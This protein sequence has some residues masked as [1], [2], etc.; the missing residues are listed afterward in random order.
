MIIGDELLALR[1]L[2][3]RPAPVVAGETI[4]LTYGRPTG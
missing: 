4:G 1:V 3:G 2:V